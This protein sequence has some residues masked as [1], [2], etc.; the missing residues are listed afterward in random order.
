M[1]GSAD[2]LAASEKPLRPQLIMTAGAKGGEAAVA[3]GTGPAAGDGHRRG[4]GFSRFSRREWLTLFALGSVHFGSSLCIA[5]QAPFYPR[6]AEMKGATATE[7]GLVFGIFEL[8]SFFSSPLFGKYM[9]YIGAKRLLTVGIFVAA[10]CSVLFGLLD[11]IDDHLQFISLSFVIRTIEALGSSAAV[12]AAFSITATVFADSVATTFAT[13]EVFYGFGYI[14]GPTLG[15][16]LF[17]VGGYI[18]PFVVMGTLLALD[19]VFVC[20]ALPALP[21]ADRPRSKG[22]LLRMLRVPAVLLD[23]FAIMATAVSMGFCSATLEPHL[24][25]FDL[26]PVMVGLVFVVSGGT[27]AVTAPVVGRL[28]D[29]SVP[30]RRLMLLGSTF[31]ITSY[32]LVGPAPFLR[33]EPQLPAIVVGLI[34][35]GL[36]VAC[37]LVPCFID[38]I[39]SAVA[40]GFP[41]DIT[42]HGLV[43]GLWASSFALGDFIGPSVAGALFD[44]VGFRMATLFVIGMHLLVLAAV[45][46]FLCCDAGPVPLPPDYA[47]SHVPL[48]PTAATV[49]LAAGAAANGDARPED[50][51]LPARRSPSPTQRSGS[52]VLVL[53]A[54]KGS[55]NGAL[56]LNGVY[57]SVGNSTPLR[58]S[59]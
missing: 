6:E 22:Q 21:G 7:Y 37:I 59:A 42:T 44:A 43:S 41:D 3:A 54:R 40:Y 39:R 15:G 24:R 31:I 20:T 53:T 10:V 12:T 32:L 19:C 35:H 11:L 14:V 47:E 2:L 4:T 45:S 58:V 26:G 17:S 1:A 5:L 49:A 8:V 34:I 13:L 57:G 46:S 9:D 52:P 16:L 36:G 50:A 30:P 51:C 18:V 28:C 55:P 23:T 29:R 27:Y 33:V 56:A 25:P 48:A 38:A